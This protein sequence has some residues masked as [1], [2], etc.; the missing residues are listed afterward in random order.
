MHSKLL[1][2][3]RHSSLEAEGDLWTM[4]LERGRSKSVVV[5]MVI[6]VQPIAV[7]C[8]ISQSCNVSSLL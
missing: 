6:S 5:W 4:N 1:P 8:N 3:A 7:Y 2:Y